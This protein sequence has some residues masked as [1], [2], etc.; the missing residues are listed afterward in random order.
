MN[1]NVNLI[2]PQEQ[3]SASLVS[4]KSL[5]WITAIVL[6]VILLL[7]MAWVYMGY[8]ET[9]SVL[10]LLEQEK[11]QSAQ[12]RN[13][14]RALRKELA[15]Q[16]AILDEVMGWHRSRVPWHEVMAGI[17]PHVPETMQWR[18]LQMRQKLEV[19]KDGKPV[20]ESVVVLG[21]RYQGGEAEAQVEA[22][23]LAW[24]SEE[25]MATWVQRAEVISYQEDDTPGAAPEDRL[26]QI[27]ISFK[28]GRF[29]A[30]AR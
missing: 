23:R 3:R 30:P 11:T 4:L 21:G 12:T 27:E 26:F 2:R 20:R 29:H 13:E 25:P 24:I 8:A 17:R 22:F 15:G 6:P 7:C 28:P 1:V 10:R 5:A 14:A 16:K 19:G 18:S 9:R